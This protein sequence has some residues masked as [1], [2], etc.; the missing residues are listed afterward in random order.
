MYRQNHFRIF[1]VSYPSRATYGSTSARVTIRP[2]TTPP[3]APPAPAPFKPSLRHRIS[4]RAV[5]GAYACGVVSPLLFSP[6][7]LAGESYPPHDPTWAV[8]AQLGR[9]VFGVGLIAALTGL[10]VADN[11]RV[12]L[13]ATPPALGYI[14]VT[15][16]FLWLN[17]GA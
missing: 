7:I 13:L 5:V 16:F 15:A 6:M 2:H 1:R 3:T 8:L 11:R 9:G 10:L 12:R 14:G 4:W 17:K